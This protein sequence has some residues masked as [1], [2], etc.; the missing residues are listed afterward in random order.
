[1]L[2]RLMML[3]RTGFGDLL[4]TIPVCVVLQECARKD[5]YEL[6]LFYCG[7]LTWTW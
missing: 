7:L 2:L 6:V 3:M 5:G 1:M 4:F